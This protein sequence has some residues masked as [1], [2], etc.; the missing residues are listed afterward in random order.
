MPS[1]YQLEEQIVQLLKN[2]EKDC[3]QLEHYR[4]E[5]KKFCQKYYCTKSNLSGNQITNILLLGT[6]TI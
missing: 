3:D 6:L 1:Q 2:A 5:L 4:Q